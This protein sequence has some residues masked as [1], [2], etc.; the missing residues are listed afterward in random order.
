MNEEP[1]RKWQRGISSRKEGLFS[2]QH[3]VPGGG[4]GGHFWMGSPTCTSWAGPGTRALQC[5]EMS[6]TKN[7]PKLHG[8]WE[9]C[10]T[11]MFVMTCLKSNSLHFN[12][13]AVFAQFDIHWIF[14]NFVLKNELFFLLT[15]ISATCLH[16]TAS[17][18]VTSTWLP[19]SI[20]KLGHLHTA[21]DLILL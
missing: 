3:L 11:N 21:M 7:F 18:A 15:V 17:V 14:R 10:W 1:T 13:E 5:V 2:K 6:H 19:A 20:L 16:Q 8:F 9:F 12:K 4:V